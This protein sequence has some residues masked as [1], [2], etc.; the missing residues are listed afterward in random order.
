[1]WPGGRTF[2][3]NWPLLAFDLIVGAWKISG[4]ESL[5]ETAELDIELLDPPEVP[6]RGWREIF[7]AELDS[8]PM[9]LQDLERGAQGDGV[10]LVLERAGLT[11]SERLVIR[12]YLAG[13]EA[14][15]IASDLGWRPQTVV[16][17][18]R[19]ALQRLAD[20]RWAEPK[21]L[22]LPADPVRLVATA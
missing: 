6:E 13:D 12:G 4:A 2:H 10:E 15:T 9:I 14:P 16:L 1:M 20:P 7:A 22:R 11:T 5:E 8:Y 3:S 21:T 19:N 18:L 17:L